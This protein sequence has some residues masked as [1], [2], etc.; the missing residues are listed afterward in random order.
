VAITDS[1][2]GGIIDAGN[3]LEYSWPSTVDLALV[4]HHTSSIFADI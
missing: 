2:V 1:D 3:L 4:G